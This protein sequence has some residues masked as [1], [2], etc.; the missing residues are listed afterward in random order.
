MKLTKVCIEGFRSIESLELTDCGNFNVLIGKNNTGKSNILSAIQVFFSHINEKSIFTA[1]PNLVGKSTDFYGKNTSPINITLTF[2]LLP[3]ERDVLEQDIINDTPQAKKALQDIDT[4]LQMSVTL[5]LVSSPSSLGFV[6]KITLSGL[7]GTNEKDLLR[8]NTASAP[9]LR[10]ELNSRQQDI[11]ALQKLTRTL[12]ADSWRKGF[13]T[14]TTR[15]TSHLKNQLPEK[16]F[17]IVISSITSTREGI[18]YQDFISSIQMLAK[19]L[20]EEPLKNKIHTIAGIEGKIPSYSLDI[21]QKISKMKVIYIGED[22]KQIGKDEAAR[23][24]SLKTRRKGQEVLRDI[25]AIVSALL[26]VKI[27]AFESDTTNSDGKATAELDVDDFLVE[28]NGSG[29]RESLRLILDVE[30]ERPDILLVEEPETH[31]H[32]ALETSMMQY[33]KSTSTERQV[34][35]TTHSTNFLDTTEMKNVYLI[36]KQTSTEAQ[37]LNF[38]NAEIH[39]PRELGLRL[40][41]LFLYDTLV[42]VEGPSDEDIIRAWASKIGVNLN[43]ANVGFVRMEGSRN[44]MRYASENI[45]SFLKKRQVRLYFLI[46]SD[47]RSNQ[48]IEILEQKANMHILKKREIENY[49]IVPRAVAKF[50][51]WKQDD[52]R[53]ENEHIECSLAEI[54]KILANSAEELKQLVIDKRVNHLI[55]KSMHWKLEDDPNSPIL[56][57]V[58]QASRR[59]VSHLEETERNMQSIYYDQVREVDRIWD[60]QRFDLVPGDELLDMVCKK[61][62]VRFKKREGDGK[63]LAELMNKNEIAEEVQW[64][65][66]QIGLSN[67]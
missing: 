48:E 32:P 53:P 51:Q 57:K 40:S 10:T 16:I 56:E 26:G 13:Q 31:L 23:L 2:L 12:N 42:F 38:E 41:S 64:F 50:I 62:N 43:Q 7:N 28:V 8:I 66:R 61:Y 25:Q 49:L 59:M 54:Q 52:G 4:T 6:S 55:C 39:V 45:L 33:L 15:L 58:A 20:S 1:T 11:D 19:H 46:D 47:E 63:L 34:F 24:L 9:K 36:S 44:I 35:I 18:V 3:S 29:I 22:R 27:D 60:S 21:L 67:T 30:F 37:L 14:D 65:I 17:D 5:T